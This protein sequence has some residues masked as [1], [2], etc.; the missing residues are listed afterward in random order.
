MI[1]KKELKFKKQFPFIY[2]HKRKEYIVERI[3]RQYK[4]IVAI[5]PVVIM[6]YGF[7][8]LMTLTERI[9]KKL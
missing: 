3:E 8:K 1:Y 5:Y 2:I 4:M 7:G 6:L 9:F